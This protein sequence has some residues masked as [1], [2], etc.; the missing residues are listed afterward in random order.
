MK[1]EYIIDALSNIDEEMILEADK[2][3][4]MPV[5]RKIRW[6]YYLTPVALVSCLV[7]FIH[8]QNL[9]SKNQYTDTSP[10]AAEEAACE[11]APAE[12]EIISVYP[13][14]PYET[15]TILT[16]VTNEYDIDSIATED[17]VTDTAG[18]FGSDTKDSFTVTVSEEE[19]LAE[20]NLSEEPADIHLEYLENNGYTIPYYI[21]S[22]Q[23]SENKYMVYSVP[24][25]EVNY[26]EEQ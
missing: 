2:I 15:E 20:L 6:Q 5:K 16:A 24:A 8:S 4:H 14:Q 21:I 7:L 9:F 18:S 23:I 13:I 22:V 3:R 17:A 26:L 12:A 1:P 11:E 25:V 19:A 10:T